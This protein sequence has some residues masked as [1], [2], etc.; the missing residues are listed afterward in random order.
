M[1]SA[2]LGFLL[3]WIY[4]GGSISNAS[5][6]IP[7]VNEGRTHALTLVRTLLMSKANS[8]DFLDTSGWFSSFDQL[9]SHVY[10]QEEF[11]KDPRE[12]SDQFKMDHT[13]FPWLETRNLL[14]GTMWAP[15]E[16]ISDEQS[17]STL[18]SW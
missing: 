9:L 17:G 12:I 10:P 16:V 18:A 4:G 14:L 8:I 6:E 3:F 2:S 1:G 13:D 7:G 11:P 5:D 15:L